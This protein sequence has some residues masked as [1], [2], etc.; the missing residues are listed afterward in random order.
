MRS[1]NKKAY[2]CVPVVDEVE[3]TVEPIREK[4]NLESQK[5]RKLQEKK[6]K[7]A[8]EHQKKMLAHA[9]KEQKAIDK[10]SYKKAKEI[11]NSLKQP[12]ISPVY[13]MALKQKYKPL[14]MDVTTYN[15][16]A[17]FLPAE[18]VRKE[19]ATAYDP[20]YTIYKA[21]PAQD[22][23]NHIRAKDLHFKDFPLVDDASSKGDF[24]GLL[25]SEKGSPDFSTLIVDDV[26]RDFGY[27]PR[28]ARRRRR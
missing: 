4:R 10:N 1:F 8:F 9:K 7:L 2:Y 22:F 16:L 21:V 15:P 14:S 20:D 28:R 5:I 3:M 11:E 6:A 13:E 12:H 23:N 19:G 27:M 25:V 17:G 24:S 26:R 18:A